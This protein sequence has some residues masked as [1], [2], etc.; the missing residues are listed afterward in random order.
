MDDVYTYILTWN[1]QMC[2]NLASAAV[3]SLPDA[4]SRFYD[5]AAYDASAHW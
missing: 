3:G 1:K 5:I 4:R 2:F